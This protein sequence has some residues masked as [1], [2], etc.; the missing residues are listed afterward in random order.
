MT[1]KLKAIYRDGTFIP[2]KTCHLPNNAEVE[3]TV[4]HYQNFNLDIIDPEAR[5]EIMK[6]LLLR[7][8]RNN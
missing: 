7:M 2:Q 5:K 3:L 6:S 4:K 1:Q 8:R